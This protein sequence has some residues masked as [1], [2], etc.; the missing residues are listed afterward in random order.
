MPYTYPA[1]FFLF[2][3]NVIDV[4]FG[5]YSGIYIFVALNTFIPHIVYH[6][7]NM[8]ARLKKEKKDGGFFFIFLID[9]FSRRRISMILHVYCRRSLWWD[10]E[11]PT[12]FR[13]MSSVRSRANAY[14]F[15]S[16][17]R[18]RAAALAYSLHGI[19]GCKGTTPELD[20]FP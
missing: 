11:E 14:F 17:I 3:I 4:I 13:G 9:K 20:P 6:K 10:S 19:T 8:R 7:P 12:S 15:F 18:D 16:F 2:L 5:D 1:F